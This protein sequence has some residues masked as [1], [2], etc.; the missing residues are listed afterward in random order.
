MFTLPQN[1]VTIVTTMQCALLCAQNDV[2]L[3]CGIMPTITSDASLVPNTGKSIYKMFQNAQQV[4]APF[5]VLWSSDKDSVLGRANNYYRFVHD[6]DHA[7]HYLRGRGTTKL[8]DELFLNLLMCKKI[9]DIV[10]KQTN[11]TVLASKCFIVLYHDLIGQAKFYAKTS[12]FVDNQLF[13]TIGLLKKDFNF[14]CVDNADI[15][16]LYVLDLIS[17]IDC[18]IASLD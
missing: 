12:A 13:F 17:E 14:C 16:A 1:L 11:N 10:L 6:I 7:L 15:L 8:K 2:I 18:E 9:H 3:N 4:G 5:F